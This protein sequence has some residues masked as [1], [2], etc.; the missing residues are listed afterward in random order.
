MDPAVELRDLLRGHL[1]GTK[2]DLVAVEEVAEPYRQLLCHG[3]DM[4][5][6]LARFHGGEVTLEVLHEEAEPT[7]YRREV[8]LKVGEK[9]VEYGVIQVFLDNF[10]AEIRREILAGGKP[11]GA[12]LNDSGMPYRSC[13][14]GFFRIEHESLKAD[15]FPSGSGEF[16]FGRYNRLFDQNDLV[17]ARIIELLPIETP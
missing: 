14:V 1:A 11:L 12:I 13:P 8:I 9:V 4:T 15:F 16:L 2:P 7:I 3:Q 10:P 17:L 6:T 5:S